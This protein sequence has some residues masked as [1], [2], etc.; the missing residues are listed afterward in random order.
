ML[1]SSVLTEHSHR[2]KKKPA[3]VTVTP[4]PPGRSRRPPPAGFLHPWI[5]V[6]SS[7]MVHRNRTLY[8]VLWGLAPFPVT[9]SRLTCVE[10]ASG[11]RT[12]STCP[13]VGARL[14]CFPLH[15][16]LSREALWGRDLFKTLFSLE[17]LA[18]RT[19]DSPS[20]HSTW[21]HPRSSVK[22][23]MYYELFCPTFFKNKKS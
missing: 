13:P 23:I 11:R 21:T 20:K 17:S 22:N 15:C 19:R 4:Q 9:C 5:W 16:R 1:S 7:R 8:H 6:C 14:G 2:P 3:P 10:P 18:R 12:A